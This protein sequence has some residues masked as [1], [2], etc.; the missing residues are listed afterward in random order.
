MTLREAAEMALECCGDV[1]NGWE[2]LAPLAVRKAAME[3]LDALRAALA[4]PDGWRQCA[5][6]QRTTQ[7][8]GLL[9][10]AVAVEREACARVCEVHGS[11]AKHAVW[12]AEECAA[13][14]RARGNDD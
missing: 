3:S 2:S 4:E 9:E 12:M 1:V 10:E 8:C 13:L 5:V 6:G 7:Y 14:I 11:M